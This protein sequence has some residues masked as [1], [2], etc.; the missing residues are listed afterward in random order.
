MYIYV[1]L[2]IYIY[3]YLNTY[4]YI[5]Y[6]NTYM[7]IYISIYICMYVLHHLQ[8]A[9]VHRP[10]VAYQFLKSNKHM[11]VCVCVC[12]CIYIYIVIYIYIYIHTYIHIFPA[13]SPIYALYEQAEFKGKRLYVLHICSI[14]CHP[15]HPLCL[16][17]LHSTFSLFEQGGLKGERLLS[18][19]YILHSSILYH[20]F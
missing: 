3:T 7:Y 5:I 20:V 16:F 9:L 4:T 15:T 8:E 18:C 10:R 17:F 19:I 11:C 14:F 1:Y 13:P 6:S 12:R 2:Y